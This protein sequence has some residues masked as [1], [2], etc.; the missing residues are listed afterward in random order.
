MPLRA[1]TDDLFGEVTGDSPR[2]LALHGWGRDRTD[3][4]AVLEGIEAIALDLPG[5]GASPPPAGPW[6]AHEYAEAIVPVL[7]RFD[8]PPV[9]VGH[10]FGGRVGVCLAAA[11]HPVAGLVLAGVPLLRRVGTVK[12]RLGYRLIRWAA[13]VGV[14]P[15]ARLEAAR[16]KYGSADYRAA[17]GVMRDVLVRVVN[18]TYEAELGDLDVPVRLLWG[19]DDAAA[20]VWIVD[21]AL[22]LLATDAGA[23]IVDGGHD[24]VFEEPQ[25]LR[26]VIAELE[27]LRA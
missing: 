22:D 27:G 19:R 8:A 3:F 10:S 18:E 24:A 14:L 17:E 11:G 5:F 4:A 23:T 1:L 20:G 2:V 13:G 25:L 6:G 26:D 7:D 15:E 12:P 21:E 16:R 9:V